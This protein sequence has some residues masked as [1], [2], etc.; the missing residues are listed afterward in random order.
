MY[1]YLFNT[2]CPTKDNNSLRISFILTFL[3]F[4]FMKF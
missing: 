4:I 1:L 2:N 3:F